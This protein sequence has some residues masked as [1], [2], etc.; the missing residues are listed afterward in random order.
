MHGA[1]RICFERLGEV[2]SAWESL[3]HLGERYGA[4]RRDLEC[5]LD[6]WGVWERFGVLGRGLERLQEIWSAW[7]SFRA[8]GRVLEHLGGFWSV[9]KR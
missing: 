9:H 3:A 1:Y 4:L 2:W 5:L 8:L 6:V 7:E